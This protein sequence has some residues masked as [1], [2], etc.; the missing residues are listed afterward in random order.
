[1]ANRPYLQIVGQIHGTPYEEFLERVGDNIPD[2]WKCKIWESNLFYK[3]RAFLAAHFFLAGY[4]PEDALVILR[5]CNPNYNEDRGNKIRDLMIW[6]ADAVEG[7]NRR[8][9][10]FAYNTLL[11]YITDLNGENRNIRANE[12][13]DLEYPGGRG[14]DQVG[15]G[16]PD[17]CGE[18][19]AEFENQ[20]VIPDDGYDEAM[21]ALE[22]F[23][24]EIILQ[25]PDD[26]LPIVLDDLGYTD[27]MDLHDEMIQPDFF[28]VFYYYIMS[29]YFYHFHDFYL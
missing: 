15:R 13:G 12:H 18:F 2:L 27:R 10:Y 1:M 25:V 3:D 24:S 16:F 20:F 17:V 26:T 21:A 9:R 8:A 6:F 29:D 11:G 23:G 28:R 7:E 5:Y 19:V 22:V 14:V 4:M